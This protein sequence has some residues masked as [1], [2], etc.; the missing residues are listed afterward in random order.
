MIILDTNVISELMRPAPSGAVLEWVDKQAVLT[1]YVT[2]ITLGEIRS[3][4]AILPDG[5]RKID[6]AQNFEDG[7]RPLFGDRVLSFDEPASQAYSLL[8]ATAR[9]QGLAI[10]NVDGL[11]AGI[12]RTHGFAIATGDVSPFRAAGLQVINPFD[13]M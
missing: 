6:L 13:G 9:A 1:L 2:A 3:G 7:I 4:I 8:R 11:I 5:R 12:A 10:G